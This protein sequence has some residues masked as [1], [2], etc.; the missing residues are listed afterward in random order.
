[1]PRTM[2]IELPIPLPTWN[3]ILGMQHFERMKLRHLLTAFT[4]TSITSGSDWPTSMEFQGKLCSTQLL[5]AEYFMMTRPS[6]SRRLAIR[7]LKESLKEQSSQ[8]R[9]LRND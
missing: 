2:T 8:S 7:K 9:R 5:R 4:S 1:M 3:R 6:S